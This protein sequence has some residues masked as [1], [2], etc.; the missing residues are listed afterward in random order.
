[1]GGR[2]RSRED[3]GWCVAALWVRAPGRSPHRAWLLWLLAQV[4]RNTESKR[5][6]KSWTGQDT[7]TAFLSPT[8]SQPLIPSTNPLSPV[9]RHAPVESQGEGPQNNEE[10]LP[11][12]AGWGFG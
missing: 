7:H 12:P 6:F 9:N 1:M 10:S 5:A 2:A 8:S 11:A 4:C 3:Q